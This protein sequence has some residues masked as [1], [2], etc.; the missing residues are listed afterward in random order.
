MF[1]VGLIKDQ[2]IQSIIDKGQ[3]FI[4]K[5]NYNTIF[6]P[7]TDYKI[8]KVNSLVQSM[9]EAAKT[10]LDDPVNAN[11]LKS[12]TNQFINDPK[13]YD[14]IQRTNAFEQYQKNVEKL[15]KDYRDQNA[16]EYLDAIKR[17][18]AGDQSAG[19]ILKTPP[20][21]DPYKDWEGEFIN[22][23][24]KLKADK[25]I[26]GCGSN[27]LTT[28]EGVTPER[29]NQLLLNGL[30]SES[31]QQMQ[32]DYQYE[33]YTGMTD[34]DWEGWVTD[35]AI[36][37]GQI[38]SY[39]QQDA[40][41][42]GDANAQARL[43]LAKAA[44][45]SDDTGVPAP[46]G[47]LATPQDLRTQILK[48]YG[49]QGTSLDNL[50]AS[51]AM[52]LTD[53][54]RNALLAGTKSGYTTMI[55]DFQEKMGKSI[56]NMMLN[57]KSQGI[58]DLDVTTRV[59]NLLISKGLSIKKENGKILVKGDPKAIENFTMEAITNQ[60]SNALGGYTVPNFEPQE[61]A[62]QMLA[63]AGTQ[64]V[65]ISVNNSSPTQSKEALREVQSELNSGEA[66]IA[67]ITP[68][69]QFGGRATM[70]IF[71]PEKI[72]SAGKLPSKK[73]SIGLDNYSQSIFSDNTNI[74]NSLLQGQLDKEIPLNNKSQFKLQGSEN[75]YQYDH[76]IHTIELD[77]NN[78]PYINTNI[79][80]YDVT[81]TEKKKPYYENYDKWTQEE[82]LPKY[83]NAP[84]NTMYKKKFYK[85]GYQDVGAMSILNEE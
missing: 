56:Y 77:N 24:E 63:L 59:N 45:I 75:V 42:S 33:K 68:N 27:Y 52:A 11:K 13:V 17:F 58:S 30:S 67:S 73:Y 81:D 82:V 34:K 1:K 4:D 55:S 9:N 47:S 85:P 38:Y 57:M 28:T 21:I 20:S 2:G 15:G 71:V 62:K 48:N 16:L 31:Y 61:A 83:M 66:R 6:N 23:L 40:K 44:L 32:K 69:S 22:G 60:N 19:S 74:Y 8:S 36:T 7:D 51:Q 46:V 26:T 72:T 64:G 3:D 65:T 84:W 80:Y 37:K 76:A 14:A 18:N 53:D 78:N 70:E 10:N 29:I 41:Y 54:D 39:T 5:S 79:V 49:A 50:S 35:K 25:T 43:R 12:I